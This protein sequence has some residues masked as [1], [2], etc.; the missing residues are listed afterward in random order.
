MEEA[1]PPIGDAL[2]SI[3]RYSDDGRR[4]LDFDFGYQEQRAGQPLAGDPNYHRRSATPSTLI[5]VLF[6]PNH[7]LN[8]SLDDRQLFDAGQH[9]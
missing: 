2:E 1:V 5:G 3:G 9:S 6:H 4:Q 8:Q 7:L